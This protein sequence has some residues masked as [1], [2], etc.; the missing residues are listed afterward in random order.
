MTAIAQLANSLPFCLR[1]FSVP[2]RMSAPPPPAPRSAPPPPPRRPGGER[3]HAQG[4]PF[5][6]PEP[7]NELRSE[8]AAKKAAFV[9]LSPSP[10]PFPPV[11]QPRPP[12]PLPPRPRSPLPTAPTRRRPPCPRPRLVSWEREDVV[13]RTSC[14]LFLAAAPTPFH[15]VARALT[16]LPFVFP[17]PS[18]MQARASRRSASPES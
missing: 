14:V 6:G 17:T 7:L 12:R 5:N 11:A 18:N 9:L 8:G 15:F 10:S 13:K 2:W 16:S 1:P 4:K 3:A